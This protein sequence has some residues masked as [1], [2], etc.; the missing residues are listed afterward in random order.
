[1]KVNEYWDQR[2][3][4]HEKNATTDDVFLRVLERQVLSDELNKLGCGADS[5]I[6]DLGCGDGETSW[7]LWKE[8]GCHV[9]GVDYSPAMIQ[10]AKKRL[11][12]ISRM[13]RVDF[14]LGDVREPTKLL[15]D[16]RFDFVMTDRCLIN[17]ESAEEQF[18]LIQG[19]ANLLR[20]DGYFLAIENFQE[21]Q[22]SLNYLRKLFDLP[23]IPIRWHNRYF[24]EWEFECEARRYFREIRKVDFSS[25]YYLA[26][27][28]IYS[29]MCQLQ[30][31]E[32]DYWHPIH[33]LSTK[34]PHAG[35]FSP[36]KL[37][38]MKK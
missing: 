38:V 18:E 15:G 8:F 9:L 29:K 16:M 12:D 19:I 23:P 35:D 32:P 31:V 36:I 2:A 27:R 26:T 3:Q 33:Q 37:F 28:V 6:L 11:S 17:L 22:E 21:G 10:L 24:N 34:L 13:P 14:L 1:M 30:G 20:P 7:H 4:S 5:D 25:S